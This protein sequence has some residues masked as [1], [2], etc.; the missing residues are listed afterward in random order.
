MYKMYTPVTVKISSNEMG[1]NC[2]G[3]FGRI[4]LADLEV[5]PVSIIQ[6]KFLRNNEAVKFLSST[7][8]EFVNNF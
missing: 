2:S 4:I 5:L 3:S 8:G 6:N 1:E 7:T